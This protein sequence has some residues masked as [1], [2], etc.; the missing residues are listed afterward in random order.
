[1]LVAD[2]TIVLQK[3]VN[4][5]GLILQLTTISLS[6]THCDPREIMVQSRFGLG[7]RKSVI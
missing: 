2:K 3:V 1:M 5:T 7:S 4:R 6:I